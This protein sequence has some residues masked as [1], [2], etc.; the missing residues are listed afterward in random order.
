MDQAFVN[1]HNL[2]ELDQ[3]WLKVKE[4]FNKNYADELNRSNMEKRQA[5]YGGAENA[6]EQQEDI[7]ATNCEI[8]QHIN[9]QT[10]SIVSTMENLMQQLL[11]GK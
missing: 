5:G 7:A 3:M 11:S 1:W 9:S 10:E 4:H 6:T 2:P 8:I